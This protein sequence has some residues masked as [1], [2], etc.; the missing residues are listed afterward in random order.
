MYCKYFYTTLRVHNSTFFQK[1]K[2]LGNFTLSLTQYI[3]RSPK[4]IK[5]W[6]AALWTRLFYTWQNLSYL[7]QFIDCS[8]LNAFFWLK[9]AVLKRLHSHFVSSLIFCNV[10][11]RK[12]FLGGLQ[13]TTFI[14]L[15]LK[16]LR[17]HTSKT[18]PKTRRVMCSSYQQLLGKRSS[19]S[20]PCQAP[21]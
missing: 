15:C 11:N 17:S 1:F 21:E 8:T 19:F 6:R 13:C 18:L 9:L 12:T 20:M 3:R 7:H 4:N 16:L 2:I 5:P 14:C 10:F